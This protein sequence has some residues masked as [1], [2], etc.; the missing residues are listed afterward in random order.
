MSSIDDLTDLFAKIGFEEPK[1]KEI[2]K[3]KKVSSSLEFLVELTSADFPWDKT[4]RALIHTLASS[5]KGSEVANVKYIVDGIGKND[6]KTALQ[7]DAAL[8]YIKSKGD[9]ATVE[10]MNRES[11]V[12]I[13]I[14]EDQVR[15]RV[16]QYI[17]ENKESIIEERYKLV[18]GLFA[19]IKLLPE[20]KWAEPRLFKP[21]LLYTSRC[22]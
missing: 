14:T 1:V 7:V 17:E 15:A 13:E 8:K 20:L 18:P 16:A 5:L 4:T 6:L 11:G 19:K 22:V 9:D 2:L 3:N 21:C 10:E 12:G